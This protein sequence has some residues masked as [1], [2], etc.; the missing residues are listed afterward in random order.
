MAALPVTATVTSRT[1]AERMG[2]VALFGEKYG[3][4]VRVV[5]IGDYSKELCGGT[6]V[7][8][9]SDLGVLKIVSESSVASGVRRIEAVAGYHALRYID[10]AESILSDV[11][12]RLQVSPADVPAHVDRL[13]A[14]VKNLERELARLRDKIQRL[15]AASS[16]RRRLK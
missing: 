15:R 10:E 3:E 12:Q 5:S 7:E 11:A 16:R 13:A 14:Q 4:R 8:R 1:E 9:T 2:A 6:H